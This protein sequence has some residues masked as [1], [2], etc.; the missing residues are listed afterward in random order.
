MEIA[1]SRNIE[2]THLIAMRDDPSKCTRENLA[3]LINGSEGEGIYPMPEMK[4]FF[5]DAIR[6]ING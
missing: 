2:N 6:K 4:I 5:L 1:D 3:K